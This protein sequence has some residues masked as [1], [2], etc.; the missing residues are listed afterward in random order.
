VSVKPT[1]IETRLGTGNFLRGSAVGYWDPDALQ[2][3]NVT[4]PAFSFVQTPPLFCAG[5]NSFMLMFTMPDVIPGA[6]QLTLEYPQQESISTLVDV[7]TY[8]PGGFIGG[9]TFLLVFGG[10]A[11]AVAQD[12][13]DGAPGN[14]ITTPARLVWWLFSIAAEQPNG[15]TDTTITMRLWGCRR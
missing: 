2:M 13:T 4:V 6:L 11:A 8:S 12:F 14:P 15:D 5:F 10:Q 7:C 3:N 9:G 1:L